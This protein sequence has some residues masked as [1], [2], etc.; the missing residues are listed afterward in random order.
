MQLLQHS[1]VHTDQEACC[2]AQAMNSQPSPQPCIPKSH[3]ANKLC[4]ACGFF[5]LQPV[6]ALGSIRL[7]LPEKLLVMT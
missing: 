3:A 6:T 7:S 2:N 4:R 1:A 5:W